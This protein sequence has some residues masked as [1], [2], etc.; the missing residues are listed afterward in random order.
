MLL[1]PKAKLDKKEIIK[2]MKDTAGFWSVFF[3]GMYYSRTL[4]SHMDI[5]SDLYK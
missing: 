1:N 5:A 2:K 4:M 3:D